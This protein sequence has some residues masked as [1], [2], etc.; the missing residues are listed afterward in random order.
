M[1]ERQ[2]GGHVRA[3]EEILHSWEE[4]TACHLCVHDH[5]RRLDACHDRLQYDPIRGSHRKTYPEVCGSCERDVCQEYCMHRLNRRVE[6]RRERAFLKRCHAGVLEIVA[7]VYWSGAHVGTLF[8]GLWRPSRS[9]AELPLPAA[10]RDRLRILMRLLPVLAEGLAPRFWGGR[11]AMI[12]ITGRAAAIND[13][14][15]A[16]CRTGITL[17]SMAAHLGLSASRASHLIRE[18]T[19][20]TFS[21]LVQAKR[22]ELAEFYLVSSDYR[23]KEVAALSGF[24]SPE[25]FCRIFRRHHGRTPAMFRKHE[26]QRNF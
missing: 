8:A 19:G 20:K 9:H 13:F 26:Q 6:Q 1:D 7:P 2:R 24:C 4:L 22:L 21:Q 25:H 10:Q 23:L 17:T 12:P 15:A 18:L 16:Q 5:S 11:D 3:L 14:I